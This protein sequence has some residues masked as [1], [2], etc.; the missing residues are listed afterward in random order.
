MDC[1]V[2]AARM[3]SS[4]TVTRNCTTWTSATVATDTA[5]GTPLRFRKRRLMAAPPTPAGATRATTELARCT[6]VDRH[7]LRR[8][9]L[10]AA[11]A[12]PAP[13]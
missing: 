1:P 6:S 7:T 12:R 8:T 10:K 13:T 11:S 3:M 2:I 4:T 5:V 9:G